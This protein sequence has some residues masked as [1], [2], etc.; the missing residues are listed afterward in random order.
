M[1]FHPL[2]DQDKTKGYS[3]LGFGFVVWTDDSIEG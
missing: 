2:D 3:S 1:R